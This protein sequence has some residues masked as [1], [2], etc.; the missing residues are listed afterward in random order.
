[1]GALAA[2][3]IATQP[4]V[5]GPLQVLVP[6]YFYPAGNP[7][8]WDEMTTA[9]RIIDLTAILNP[10]SG[11]GPSADPNYVNAVNNLHA[12]GGHVVGYVF[13][14]YGNRSESAVEADIR[15]YISFYKIDGIFLDQQS[16]DP[17]RV[18]YY[19][20]LYR[21]IKAQNPSFEVI[22]NPGTNTLEDYLSTPT[23]DVVVTFENLGIN[24]PGD[25][26]AAWTSKYAPSHFANLIHTES[27]ASAMAADLQL[28]QQRNVGWVFVTDAG[29]PN[30][31]DRL[32]SYW[33]QEAALIAGAPEPSSAWLLATGSFI[34]L[35]RRRNR[36]RG[37]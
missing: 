30:P 13:T 27:S 28:A 25:V 31:Y 17:T 35:A 29:L 4:S 5:A 6:A 11:P 26:P 14:D 23:A 37:G 32:P 8:Y 2:L 24:Y 9:A 10:A 34:L 16:T 7:N 36:K 1:V 33:D 18:G 3:L 19:A 15:S 12:A 20:D 21:F 22:A